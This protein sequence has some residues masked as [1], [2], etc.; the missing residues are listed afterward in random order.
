MAALKA[1]DAV[2]AVFLGSLLEDEA[3]SIPDNSGPSD[4]QDNHTQSQNG[5]DGRTAPQARQARVKGQG[6]EVIEEGHRGHEGQGKGPIETIIL[7]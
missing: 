6:D 4:G 3:V 1:Q 7:A 5:H 2:E